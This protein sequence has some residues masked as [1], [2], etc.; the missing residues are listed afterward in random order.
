MTYKPL[1]H[2]SEI[3]VIAPSQSRRVNQKAQ[4]K[5]AHQRLEKLGYVISFGKNVDSIF[6][7]ATATAQKRAEDFNAAFVD[8]NVKAVI[9]ING[10]W[11]A[12]EILPLINWESVANNPKPF[13]GFSDIT[14][15]LNAIYAKTGNVSYLGPNFGTLGYMRSWEYT[16]ANFNSV[17]K[18]EHPLKLSRSKEWGVKKTDRFKTK[19]WKVLAQGQAEAVLLGGNLGTLYLLQGTEFQPS[20]NK[21]FIFALE[22]DDDAGKYTAREISRRFESLLQLPNFRK[23]L[24]GLIISRFQPDSKVSQSDIGSIVASKQLGDIPIISGVDFGHT[25]PMLTLPIGGIVRL[26]S[27]GSKPKLEIL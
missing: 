8:D 16:L 22:D 2:G 13:V 3:R 24:K 21:S 14:V 17:L 20:F 11:S 5:R 10:G 1:E 27:T 26:S 18:Q 25:L 12:N 23:N 19:P 15:L 4:Y 9:A 7:L 6:C